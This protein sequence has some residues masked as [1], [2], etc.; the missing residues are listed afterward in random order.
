MPYFL[1][2]DAGGTKTNC[3][4]ADETRVLARASTG[5]VKLM[6][7]SGQE[8]SARLRSVLGEV[9]ASANVSLGNITRTCVGLAGLTIP[10]VRAWATNAISAQV[11]GDLILLGDEEIALDA[12]FAG[13]PGIL[14]IAGTGSN[15]IGR[16][17]NGTVHQ[18]GGWGPILGDEGA[19]YWIGLEAIRAALRA[20]DADPPHSTIQASSEKVEDTPSSN[21]L[22][23]IQRHWNLNSLA[24]LVAF[25]NHRGDAQRPAPDFA[26]LAPTV[27]HA[28]DHGNPIATNILKCAG[29]D[30]AALV[31]LVARKIS[32]NVDFSA[33]NL[34][35]GN[36]EIAYTGSVLTHI[37]LVRA[38]MIDRLGFTAP[39][40]RVQ[41]SAVDPLEG[42]LWRARKA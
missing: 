42:A 22:Y 36:L 8:A 9:A 20:R 28:A 21:L 7:V 35:P 2:I 17:R 5:S 4:L 27:A 6:R 10:A 26:S 39:T 30:L 37:A 25:A 12:A 19:G 13:G 14:V 11:S 18:A 16:A 29:E 40:A 32:A 15:V 41:A 24:D 31:T 34:E 3:L 23:E 1:A 38:A 33:S